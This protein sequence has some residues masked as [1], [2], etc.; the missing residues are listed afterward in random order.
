MVVVLVTWVKTGAAVVVRAATT[1]RVSA[2]FLHM[3]QL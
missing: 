1:K 2:G 3:G